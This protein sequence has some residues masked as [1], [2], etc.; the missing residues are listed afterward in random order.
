MIRNSKLNICTPPQT[1]E[2][3][4]FRCGTDLTVILIPRFLYNSFLDPEI[5]PKKLVDHF[6]KNQK[7]KE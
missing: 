7:Y 2:N 3:N 4:F 6:Y 5:I 1:E